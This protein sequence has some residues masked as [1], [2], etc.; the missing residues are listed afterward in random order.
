M[1]SLAA[2]LSEHI[3]PMFRGVPWEFHPWWW[4]RGTGATQEDYFSQHLTPGEIEQATGMP[5][6]QVM[7]SVQAGVFQTH[8]GRDYRYE[9]FM[10]FWGEK[11]SGNV[12]FVFVSDRPSMERYPAGLTTLLM[13][14]LNCLEGLGLG[15]RGVHFTDFIKRRGDPKKH[16]DL[17][18]GDAPARHSDIL[19]EEICCLAPSG[20]PR[21]CLIP[22]QAKTQKLLKEHSIAERLERRLGEGRAIVPNTYAVWWNQHGLKNRDICDRW[23]DVLSECG[24]G[25]S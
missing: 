21:L 8:R 17:P 24:E 15:M 22:V 25:S 9:G 5:I 4:P 12:Q 7:E 2:L 20:G 3:L 23:R 11:I 14:V 16:L 1:K 19:V 10:G 18:F 6:E 13:N